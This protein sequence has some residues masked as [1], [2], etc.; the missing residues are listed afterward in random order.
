MKTEP[1]FVILGNEYDE[2]LRECLMRVL[3]SLGATQI[4]KFR[5]I[6]GSQEIETL[7]VDLYGDMLVVEAETFVGLG[8]SGPGRLVERITSLVKNE[9]GVVVNGDES[10][11]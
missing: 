11:L 4:D 2:A 5:G 9:M 7:R 8:I 6:G 1:E 3:K 10:K